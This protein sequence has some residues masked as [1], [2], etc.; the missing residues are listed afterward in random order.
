MFDNFYSRLVSWL[1]VLLPLTALAILSTLFLLS[2]GV[3]TTGI[4]PYADVDVEG[5]T[6]DQRVTAPEFSGVTADGSA[7]TIRA[8]QARPDPDRFSR[9][10]AD[11]INAH[12]DLA[13]GEVLEITARTGIIDTEARQMEVSGGTLLEYSAGYVVETEGLTAWFETGAMQ[14]YGPVT[15]LAP[16]GRLEAGSMALSPS[17]IPG[18]PPRLTFTDGVKLIYEPMEK[19]GP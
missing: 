10:T 16:I 18:L 19:K 5:L 3:D 17:N 14:S 4:I 12:V 13:A 6:R 9:L 7:I 15:A 1:K 2:R 8:E 11:A